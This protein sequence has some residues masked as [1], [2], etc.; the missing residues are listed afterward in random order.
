VPLNVALIG[1]GNIS[2]THLA[3]LKDLPAG[4]V[5]GLF[6]AD[7]TRAQQRATEFGIERV[8]QTQNDLLGDP[9]V[10]VVGVLVP[11]DLHSRVAIDALAAGKHVVTE[12]PMA[13]TLAECD[14]MIAAGRQAG[15]RMLTVQNRIFSPAY[16]ATREIIQNGTIGTVFLAQTDGFEGPDTVFRTS[17]LMTGRPGNGVLLA[18][19]VHPAYALRWLLGEV[20]QVSA[21]FGGR[22]VVDTVAE[23]TAIVTF[24]FASGVIVSMTATFGLKNGPFDHAIT[25][26]GDEGYLEIRGQAG[27]PPLRVISPRTYGDKNIHEVALPESSDHA[28]HFRAMWA[29]YLGSFESGQPGRVDEIDGRKAVEMILA[30]HRSNELGQVVRL[31][32]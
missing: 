31:P 21:T 30:A 23:D 1:S 17:W 16:E 22:K 15:R 13:A 27:V 29:D 10:Q 4:K 2:R 19:A 32:L 28:A 25:V 7:P 6:D 3:A 8:Y 11:P 26:F 5:V 14:A 20:D 9:S 24:R 18:Q 12:K